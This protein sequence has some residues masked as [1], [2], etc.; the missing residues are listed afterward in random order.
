MAEEAKAT[1][2]ETTPA[3]GDE[4]QKGPDG[5]TAEQFA[6]VV[7]QLEETRKAQAGSDKKVAELNKMLEEARRE[8]QTVEKTVEERVAELQQQ[9][10]AKDLSELRYKKASEAGMPE[11]V[12]L[13]S[14]DT[15]TEDGLAQY[16]EALKGFI[17]E[18]KAKEVEAEIAKRFPKGNAPQAGRKADSE[19]TYEDL[20]AM[21]DTQLRSVPKDVQARI[22]AAAAK[23]G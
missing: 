7:K 1:E 10:Q 9:L 3:Q 8:K 2:A 16:I 14:I 5:P 21:D 23:K 4:E 18:K 22:V 20:L 13:W 17:D 12:K 6:E 19:L 11:V 15:S